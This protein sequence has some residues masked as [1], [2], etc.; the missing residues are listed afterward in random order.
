VHKTASH[1]WALA[2]DA[3]HSFHTA[4]RLRVGLLQVLQFLA[5]RRGFSADGLGAGANGLG[6]G[7]NGFHLARLSLQHGQDLVE[8]RHGGRTGHCWPGGASS[9]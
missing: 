4:Q 8:S 3:A 2:L 9:S 6:V 1:L 7:A 5:Q